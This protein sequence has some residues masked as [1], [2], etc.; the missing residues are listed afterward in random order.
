MTWRMRRAVAICFP[1][2]LTATM[3][4]SFIAAISASAS[5]LLPTEAAPMGQTRTPFAAA[6]RSTIPRVM[7]ALSFT[8]WVFGMQQTA[9]NPPR[10]AERVPV[11]MVS[12]IS[13]PGSRRWQCRSM[14]PGATIYPLA[15]KTSASGAEIPAPI[16]SMRSPESNTSWTKSDFVAGASTRPFFISRICSILGRISWFFF[17][18]GCFHRGAADQ[19]IEQRHANGEA[20]GDLI[21][22]AGLR[23]VGDGGIDFEAA[24]HGPGMQDQR[25]GPSQFQPRGGELV[26]QNVFFGGDGRFVQPFG[27]HPQDN[28][29]VGGLQRIFDARNA[30]DIGRE[31]FEFARH[32]H[33]RAAQGDIHAELAEQE[34][35]RACNPAMQN[36]AEDGEIQPIQFSFAVANGQRIQ[37]RLGGMLVGAVA[38]IHDRH[39]Q[40][41]CDELRCTR[42]TV[43]IHNAAGAHGF[44]STDGIEERLTLFQT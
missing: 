31:G 6:A 9:V 33:G 36:V 11:S 32:P 23:T 30:A 8:G 35:V 18:R 43:S 41:I 12:D 22:D 1:S 38:S 16:F 10:A 37:Q 44:E 2:S 15:S 3:P 19:V 7:E 40:A 39:P 34:N 14:N 5:P 27:L 25:V 13:W 4:A 20:V 24:N 26:S 29:G 17:C 21:E 28:D 42:R